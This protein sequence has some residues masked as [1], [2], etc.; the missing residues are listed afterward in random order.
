[1]ATVSGTDFA[2]KGV[3]FSIAPTTNVTFDENT[4]FIAFG[5]NASG[6]YTVTA[7]SVFDPTKKG[8]ADITV[9]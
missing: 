6:K 8:T 7:T 1:M 3:K 5:A 2:N 4:G 9:S